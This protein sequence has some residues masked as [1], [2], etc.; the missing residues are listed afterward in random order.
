M[1]EGTF[2]AHK[3]AAI[4]KYV[5]LIFLTCSSLILLTTLRRKDEIARARARARRKQNRLKDEILATSALIRNQEQTIANRLKYM[6]REA[7]WIEQ[8]RKDIM[9]G[10]KALRGSQ[11]KLRMKDEFAHARKELEDEIVAISALI[12]HEQEVVVGCL[13]DMSLEAAKMQKLHMDIIKMQTALR[14]AEMRV[15]EGGQ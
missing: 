12:H 4:A 7:A 8:L 14:G 1:K 9:K 2:G 15:L 11:I 10:Q 5:H 6:S 3:P 13:E